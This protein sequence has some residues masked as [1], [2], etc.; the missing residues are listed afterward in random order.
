MYT[1][2]SFA[3]KAAFFLLTK[4]NIL[5]RVR[6]SLINYLLTKT[7]LNIITFYKHHGSWILCVPL[8]DVLLHRHKITFYQLCCL[9]MLFV[10]LIADDYPVLYDR[11]FMFEMTHVRNGNFKTD[12]H[13]FTV[14]PPMIALWKCLF[15]HSQG[16]AL[17]IRQH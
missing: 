9:L 8:Y 10:S 4:A 5:D 6:W 13:P 16:C 7:E 3:T 15:P 14:D 11:H 2:L 17:H 12:D 1:F